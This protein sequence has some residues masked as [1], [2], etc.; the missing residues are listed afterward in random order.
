MRVIGSKPDSLQRVP[1][2]GTVVTRQELERADPQDVGEMLRRVPG[3]E[4]RQENGGGQRLDIGIHGLDSGRSRHVLVLEDGIPIALNPYAEADLYYAPP[5]ERMRGIEVVKGSGSILFGPQT[6][7]GVV[8]FLTL[9]PEDRQHAVVDAE[10]GTL[11]T[12]RGLASYNDS[13]GGARYVVQA[14]HRRGDGFRDE[15]FNSTDVFGKMAFDTG[16]RGVATLKL[17]FHD[18]STDSDDVGLTRAMYEANPSQSTLAPYD[19]LYLRRYE[20]SLVHEQRLSDATKLRTLIYGYITD[21]IWRRQDYV[22]CPTIIPEPDG[23]QQTLDCTAL[24]PP[25]GYQRVVGD[26]RFPNAAIAFEPSDTILDRDYQVAGVEPRLEHRAETGPFGH[27]IDLGARFLGETAHYQQRTGS[28]PTSYAGSLDAEER[29]RTLAVAAYLQDRIAFRDYLLVTPGVRVEH[30]DFH[31]VVTRQADQDV[32]SPGDSSVTGVIPGIGMIVGTRKAHVFGGLHVGWAPPRIVDAISPKGTPQ[33]VAAEQSINYEVGTRVSPTAWLHVEGTAFLTNFQ[34]QVVVSNPTA[35]NAAL[36]TAESEINAGN[37]RHVGVE[38]AAV[39]GIGKL[40]GWRPSVDVGARYTYV[41]ATFL[42]QPF[43][44]NLLP[45]APE[46]HLS[47]NLDV[48]DET[49]LG[50]QLAYVHVSEQYTDP[51]NTIATDTTGR[52]GLMPAYNIVDVTAHYRH[53]P[54]GLSV[55]LTVKN[56]LDDLYIVGRRPEGIFVSGFRLVYVGLRWD[57]DGSKKQEPR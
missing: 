40:L 46:H 37:T 12:M 44:G 43:A 7:G 25:G 4:V 14:F 1:G 50:G 24:E 26:P 53:K 38:G 48:E 2:S 52:I 5:V 23:S 17:G 39:F 6:I 49:G 51:A 34:N 41:H 22:R 30:A 29:H 45:Y 31:R 13:F 8:N 11:G 21:R 35:V 36:Q 28:S 27:T 3:V 15:A 16:E 57:W 55:R 56:A 32:F 42:D 20:A 18:D 47:A 9:T 54:T 19:H 10:G 33:Q